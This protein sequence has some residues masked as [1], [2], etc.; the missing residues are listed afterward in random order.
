[1]FNVY[2]SYQYNIYIYTIVY[3]TTNNYNNNNNDLVEK[4]SGAKN[5]IYKD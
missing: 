1:M 2:L 4:D 5:C 3:N